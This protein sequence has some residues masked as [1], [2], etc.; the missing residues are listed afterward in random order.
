MIKIFI[1]YDQREIVAYHVCSNSIIRQSTNPLS[2]SP[3]ALNLLKDYN[4]L[5]TDGSNHFIYS[6]F[7]VP[8]LMDYN[9][10]A[11]FIDGD[12]ILRDDIT[13]LW[14][15]KDDQYAVQVVKHNYKT[16]MPVKYLGS[17]NEDYPCKNWSSVILWNCSH[18]KNKSLTPQ[19]IENAT[20]AKL[21]RFTWLDE[22][23]IGEL[24]IEWNWLPDEF[25]SNEEAKLLHFTLGLPSFYEFTGSPMANE[26]HAEK[27]LT[28]YCEQP[29]LK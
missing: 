21:H 11:I 6:R 24:P 13:K 12:M 25:G 20:G 17:K 1:G 19:F 18:I 8:Y 4:E 22:S 29:K 27:I 3:L 16:K 10:W 5:H 14:N 9:G 23:D 28:N 7:L 26:W 2:I 15:L